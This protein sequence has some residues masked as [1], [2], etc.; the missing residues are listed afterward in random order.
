VHAASCGR[1]G[2]GECRETLERLAQ[3]GAELGPE[4]YARL[5]AAVAALA[6]LGQ[7]GWADAQAV[8]ALADAAGAAP[9]AGGL[10]SM[11]EVLVHEAQRDAAAGPGRPGAARLVRWE[12]GGEG[13]ARL[14][15]V[16]RRMDSG[17]GGPWDQ[18]VAA[19]CRLAAGCGSAAV[20]RLAWQ[21]LSDLVPPV[22]LSGATAEAALCAA[23]AAGGNDTQAR[24]V[25]EALRA[26]RALSPGLFQAAAAAA[27]P[28]GAAEWVRQARAGLGIPARAWTCGHAAPHSAT[29][30]G[31]RP[32]GTTPA[33]S[34]GRA[35]RWAVRLGL[36]VVTWLAWAAGS[37]SW[38]GRPA[39]R[40][41]EPAFQEECG[42][43]T[44]RPPAAARLPPSAGARRGARAGPA[45]AQRL[46]QQ[47]AGAGGVEWVPDRE[48]D[49]SWAD[50]K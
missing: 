41:P 49:P 31:T 37:R 23:C 38:S 26:R 8:L 1:T 15:G 17:Q 13:L 44:G 50:V 29:A 11:V 40:G 30:P 22:R 42:A 3:A 32:A 25:V 48:F 14:R 27:G 6:G 12:E 45:A 7:A 20:G 2:V 4:S 9:T 35:L 34:P 21:L 16:L 24:Q 18:V 28:S 43:G 33:L 39:G 36:A 47:E 5:M 46:R 10:A 19:V